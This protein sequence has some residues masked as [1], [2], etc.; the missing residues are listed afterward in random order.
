MQPSKAEAKRWLSANIRK[1][2]HTRQIDARTGRE[3]NPPARFLWQ[4]GTRFV[5]DSSDVR[6][7][8]PNHTV[9]DISPDHFTVEW[10]D[11]NGNVIHTTTYSTLPIV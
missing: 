9:T 6:C 11:E 10:R 2:I 5:L 4:A 1:E 7:F 3:W 8:T